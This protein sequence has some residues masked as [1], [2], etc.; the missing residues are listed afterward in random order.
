MKPVEYVFRIDVFTPDNLPMGRLAEYLAALAKLIGHR[1][2]THFV[3]IEKGS[4]KLVH[5]VEPVDAPKVEKRLGR[6]RS[7]EAPK[8]AMQARAEL[9]D[10]LA[11]DNA[12]GT[13]SE[14]GT[15]RVVIPFE[16]RNRPKPLTFPAF[17]E[18]ATIQGQ[19]VR[20]GGTDSTAHAIIQ[21][22]DT[23]HTNL[24]MSRDTAKR[25]A[26]LLYGPIVRLH[27]N[28]R[29]ER[30]RDGE[31]KMLDF[32][33]ERFEVLDDATIGES[34]AALRSVQ[35][36]GLMSS[37]AYLEARSLAEDDEEAEN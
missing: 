27:G 25:L 5:M 4:A 6:V 29:F 11:N 17:R 21:D 19:V 31:W 33:V 15:G 7:G 2:N 14:V 28:G 35:N 30:L 34:I 37:N 1:D 13:L 12:V 24:S 26:Q 18:D 32:K 23:S 10:L 36:N 8:E 20:V 3:K 22:G 16:G 9:D